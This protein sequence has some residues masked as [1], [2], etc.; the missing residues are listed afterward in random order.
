VLER[1]ADVTAAQRFHVGLKPRV[2]LPTRRSIPCRAHERAAADEQD[3]RRVDLEEL[4]VRVLAPT[5]GGTFATVPRE[6]SGALLHAFSRDVAGD[7]GFSSFRQILS[8]RR[9]R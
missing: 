9:Y 5:C 8:L 3:V 6:S 4:L 2:F 7:R 1:G